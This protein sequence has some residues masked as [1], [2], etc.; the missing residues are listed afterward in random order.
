MTPIQV[1]Y[2]MRVFDDH[3]TFKRGSLWREGG[4]HV[5]YFHGTP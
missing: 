2:E 3:G 5:C 4:T 1:T